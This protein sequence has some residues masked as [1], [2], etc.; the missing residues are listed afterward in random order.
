MFLYGQF[1]FYHRMASLLDV[2]DLRSIYHRT[3][4]VV[5]LCHLCKRQQ[6]VQMGN[7]IGIDLNLRDKS[8][9]IQNQVIEKTSLQ[10]E[11]LILCTQNLLFIL[12]Q[13]LRD[14]ALGLG[15]RLLAHPFCR[16]LI[17][18][19]I[20]HLQI[21]AKHIV[22]AY[23][24]RGNTCLFGLSLLYLQ[25]IILSTVGN[26]S[27]FVELFIHP[28]T[29]HAT[30]LYQLRWVVLYLALNP[31]TKTLAKIQLFPYPFQRCIISI[32]AR[33]LDGLDSLQGR[34]QLHHLTGRHT[35]YSHL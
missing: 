24:Q 30:F 6:T 16:H 25:Q 17:L 29:N 20:A 26:I 14:I 19:D 5:L 35:S 33:C 31:F 11:N 23:L 1:F 13:F 2:D 3:D 21:I 22:V 18:I 34:L 7:D 12:L 32:E 28:T 10:R 8:L 4:I 9:H 15:Q 27:Q